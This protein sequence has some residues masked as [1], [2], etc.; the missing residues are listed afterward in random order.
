MFPGTW[1]LCHRATVSAMGRLGDGWVVWG[2]ELAINGGAALPWSPVRFLVFV[3]C[4]RFLITEAWKRDCASRNSPVNL[5]RLSRIN[6]EVGEWG[7]RP[8]ACFQPIGV[9]DLLERLSSGA[10]F[11]EIRKT[12]LFLSER[13]FSPPWTAWLTRPTTSFCGREIPYR[14]STAKGA[15]RTPTRPRAG[16][17]TF[18]MLAD[19]S[20][21]SIC[22]CGMRNHPAHLISAT[23]SH[24]VG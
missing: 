14:Q 17:S 2:G 18:L 15:R 6:V 16:F 24:I 23:G 12:T 5:D 21:I 10:C 7:G 13:I 8:W 19:A 3:T 9:K 1:P 4:N 20:D 11:E 22:R